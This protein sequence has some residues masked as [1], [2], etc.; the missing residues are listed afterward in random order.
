MRT[1]KVIT[2]LM[3]VGILLSG[4][5]KAEHGDLFSSKSGLLKISAEVGARYPDL[6]ATP[7]AS[8]YLK[9]YGSKIEFRFSNT[10]GNAG[11]GHLQ[12]RAVPRG[13]KTSASQEL[14][15]DTGQVV[16]SRTVGEF[17]YH[18]THQHTHL[19][20]VC[21]YELRSGSL[22][23]PLV[24]QAEKVS[25]C[26]TDTIPYGTGGVVRRYAQCQPELQGISSGWS[27]VYGSEVPEQDL[28][29]AN[30]PAGEYYLLIILDP[31][32]K[33]IESNTSNNVSWIKVWLDPANLRVTKLGASADLPTSITGDRQFWRPFWRRGG[34]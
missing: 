9:P 20:A 29:V 11:P 10:I 26:M 27:D 21:N 8:E 7:P 15:D 12:I 18:P 30:L 28:D 3:G 17:T 5:S 19:D 24:R 31:E 4:C 14:L 13:A 23:G 2:S 6:V 32:R 16:Q 25:F 33:L 1:S 22:T 34:E